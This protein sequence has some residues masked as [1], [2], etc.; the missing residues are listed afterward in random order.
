M[1]DSGSAQTSCG[2]L[3]AI[4]WLQH[5]RSNSSISSPL[6]LTRLP[7]LL[8]QAFLSLK[9]HGGTPPCLADH[10][11]VEVLTLLWEELPTLGCAGVADF[12]SL[13]RN[14][15]SYLAESLLGG[16]LIIRRS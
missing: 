14:L 9:A 11:T 6:G 4:A 8:F 7:T 10:P 1:L 16:R 2:V 5:L 12:A 13:C 3:S 15:P